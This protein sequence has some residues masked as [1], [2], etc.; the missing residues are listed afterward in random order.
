MS[1][2]MPT[3]FRECPPESETV[4]DYDRQCFRLYI[5]LIDADSSG[6]EWHKTYRQAFGRGIGRDCERAQRQYLSHLERARWMTTAG[7]AQIL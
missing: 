7:F 1:I 5:I 4:T 3:E 2:P 6:A